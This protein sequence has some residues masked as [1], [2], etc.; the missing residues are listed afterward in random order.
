MRTRKFKFLLSRTWTR[1]QRTHARTLINDK[2][3][4][5][6]ESFIMGPQIFAVFVVENTA[7]EKEIKSWQSPST[8]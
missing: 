8:S 1:D 6:G 4:N 7:S 5:T 2:R 3:H